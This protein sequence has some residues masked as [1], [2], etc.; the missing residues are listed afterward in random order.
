[1]RK[2]S[3]VLLAAALAAVPAL[4]QM[5]VLRIPRPAPTTIQ[6]PPATSPDVTVAPPESP[7][8]DP[9]M[10]PDTAREAIA[11]LRARNKQLRQQMAVTLG[12]LQS[13]RTQLDET[14]RAGGSLVRAQCVSSALSRNTAGAEENCYASG[15]AY[16]PV[17]GTCMRQC[18]SSSQCAPG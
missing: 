6:R 15:Y 17:E 4:A 12:D 18:T 9:A 14:T 11:K 7:T 3:I 13:L 2:W 8:F 16:G 5:Q 1:M 10:T